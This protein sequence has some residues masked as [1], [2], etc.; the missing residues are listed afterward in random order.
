MELESKIAEFR[1]LKCN[2]LFCKCSME[3][4]IEIKCKK[5]KWF[6]LFKNGEIFNSIEKF[7]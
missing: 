6:S 4:I 7:L 3:S 1:C 2:A 5:C